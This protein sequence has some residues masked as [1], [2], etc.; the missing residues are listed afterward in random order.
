MDEWAYRNKVKLDFITQGNPVENA[1]VES[2]NGKFREECLNDNWFWSITHARNIIE[3][4]RID[5]N[6]QRPH[7]SLNY[8]T[9]DEFN[10]K[11][12]F[13]QGISPIKGLVQV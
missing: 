5:Y 8:L 13:L 3:E 7:S 6:G 10:E 2:F 12:R 11:W 9:P 1:Y 4:W